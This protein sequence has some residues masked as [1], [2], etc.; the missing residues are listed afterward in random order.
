MSNDETHRK[1]GK[2]SPLFT[3]REAAEYLRIS[4]RHL[5]T[6]TRTGKLP[7][8]KLG[9]SKRYSLADLDAYIA[10]RRQ[11]GSPGAEAA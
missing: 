11:E 9:R 7:A 8:I 3:V 6:I 4:E 10:R 1:P 5:W 2:S